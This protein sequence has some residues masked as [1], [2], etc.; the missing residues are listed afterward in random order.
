M[1]EKDCKQQIVFNVYCI[2]RHFTELFCIQCHFTVSRV[3]GNSNLKKNFIKKDLKVDQ[4]KKKFCT[5]VIEIMNEISA[6]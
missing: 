5:N 3:Y 6:V 2:Q 4:K 1:L